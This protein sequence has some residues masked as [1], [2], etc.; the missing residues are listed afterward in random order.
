MKIL[1]KT[2]SALLTVVTAVTMLFTG[3]VT[4]G[5]A[6]TK[7]ENS[8]YYVTYKESSGELILTIYG[9]SQEDYATLRGGAF[10]GPTRISLFFKDDND[11]RLMYLGA[12]MNDGDPSQAYYLY[13]DDY[14]TADSKALIKSGGYIYYGESETYPYAFQF[15]LNKNQLSTSALA[16][17]KKISSCR[18]GAVGSEG[19]NELAVQSSGNDV[20]ELW[21]DVPFR[22]DT[23]SLSGTP[24]SVS[25]DI[26]SL[27]FDEITN[28]AYTG[29]ALKPSVT[30]KDGGK[31]LKKGTDYTLIYKN[32]KAIGTAT[33]AVKG[34]GNYSGT[35]T[36]TFQIVPKKTILTAKRS[37]EKITFQWDAV[38][39]AEKYE[40]FYREKGA[41]K[42]KKLATVS[43]SKTSY[44]I[45]KLDK[46][47]T[48][49]FKIRSYKTTGGKKTYSK[50]SN[51]VTVK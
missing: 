23:A 36:L 33:V 30:V 15:V 8:P 34:K 2:I 9:F 49:Q 10:G 28:K 26:S 3:S 27:N 37:G 39:G 21:T 41:S 32:N 43:G 1:K 42:Y 16:G 11:I 12:V 14:P 45:S 51:V 7:T 35:K 47:K 40:I 31:T 22:E 13:N 6:A 24:V 5:A 29:E 48:Y 50:Y 4:A 44:S 17:I 46:S 20:I 38:K 18:A 25:K 19:F